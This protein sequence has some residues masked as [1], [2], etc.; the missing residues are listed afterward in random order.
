MSTAER[1]AASTITAYTDTQGVAAKPQQTAGDET[2]RE[3]G[4]IKTRGSDTNTETREDSEE[5]Y[6]EGGDIKTR[7]SSTGTSAKKD[8]QQTNGSSISQDD[9]ERGA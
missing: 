1:K 7:A 2:H 4:D 3:G 5:P 6:R 9:A 8:D